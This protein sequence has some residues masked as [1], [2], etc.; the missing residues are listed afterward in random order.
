[1]RA[2][3]ATRGAQQV[4]TQQC[5][6]PPTIT[7][8][9]I[10]PTTRYIPRSLLRTTTRTL[11]ARFSLDTYQRSMLTQLLETRDAILALSPSNSDKPTA[12][13]AVAT[14]RWPAVTTATPT[15]TPCL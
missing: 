1:M 14:T 6:G 9:V 10:S 13:R 2:C 7:L 5:L 15:L 3:G 11:E 8:P 12:C 4:P